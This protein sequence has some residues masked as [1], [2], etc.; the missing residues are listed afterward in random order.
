MAIAAA[1]A[2]LVARY[3]GMAVHSLKST[4]KTVGVQP[5]GPERDSSSRERK[6]PQSGSAGNTKEDRVSFSPEAERI[7]ELQQRDREVRVH[8]QAHAAVGGAY[9]DQPTFT[10]ER[11]PDGRSYA[12]SGEVS[13][14]TTPVAN[15]P[16]A[17]LQKAETIYRAAMAPTEPS[18]ADRAIAAKAGKMAAETRREFSER[19]VEQVTGTPVSGTRLSVMA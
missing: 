18:S 17:T 14:D 3:A 2:A 1:P 16:E 10:L 12:V 11:G 6:A 13:I 7:R 19:S 9:S 4:D 8:E 5:L 15:D